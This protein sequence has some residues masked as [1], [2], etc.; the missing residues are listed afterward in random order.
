M[1]AFFIIYEIS[2]GRLEE[3]HNAVVR[4]LVELEEKEIQN[5][6]IREE[7]HIMKKYFKKFHPDAFKK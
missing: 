7:F 3:R 4:R 5:K 1:I 2:I 6:M